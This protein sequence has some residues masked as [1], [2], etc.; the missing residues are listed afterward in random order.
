MSDDINEAFG[1]KE[2]LPSFTKLLKEKGDKVIGQ[3]VTDPTPVQAHQFIMGKRGEAQ[4]WQGGKVVVQSALDKSLPFNKVENW[5]FDIQLKDGSRYTAW[6]DKEKL[7]ALKQAIRE[8]GRCV[9]GGMIS[10]EI[11]D[12]VDVG[13]DILKKLYA[14]VLK[15]P[16]TDD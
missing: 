10:I 13:T 4:F 5:V 16:K 9:K 8:G 12:T 11:T 6:F 3:I 14:V 1:A 7:K 15:A 2:K